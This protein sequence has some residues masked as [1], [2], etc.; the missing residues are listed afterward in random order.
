[1]VNTRRRL[2]QGIGAS[3]AAL[4]LRIPLQRWTFDL[5]WRAYERGQITAQQWG[6][7]IRRIAVSEWRR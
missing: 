4:A 2:L 3:A 6:E 1:M 7:I 5:A